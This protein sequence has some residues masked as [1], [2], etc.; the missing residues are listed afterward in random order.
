MAND[1]AI[2]VVSPQYGAPDQVDLYISK[3]VKKTTKGRHLGVFDSNGNTIFKVKTN[4]LFSSRL[5]LVDA[6]GVP[7]VSLKSAKIS[8]HERWKVYK[9]DSEDSNDLLFTVKK[10]HCLQ[11][12]TQLEVFLAPNTDESACDFMMKQTYREKSCV[13]Y[14]G[15][16]DTIIAEMHNNEAVPVKVPGEDTCSVTIYPN[17]DCAFVVALRVILNEVNMCRSGGGG[18]DLIHTVVEVGLG[19]GG[20]GDGDG[21]E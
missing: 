12:R 5:I 1:K 13:I 2:V 14:R 6:A 7:V 9:G 16:S 20:D 10:S 3:K 21:G 8:L 15:Y 11:F 17:V 18:A 4:G 19:G